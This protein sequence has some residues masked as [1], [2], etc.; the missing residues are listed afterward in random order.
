MR[1]EGVATGDKARATDSVE[2]KQRAAEM[3]FGEG[4]RL[5]YTFEGGYLWYDM[6][7]H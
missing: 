2:S 5:T 6:I 7:C 3:G 1:R 4:W